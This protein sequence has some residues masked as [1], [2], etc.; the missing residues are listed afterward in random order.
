MIIVTYNV[1]N[2]YALS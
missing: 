1:G 2:N